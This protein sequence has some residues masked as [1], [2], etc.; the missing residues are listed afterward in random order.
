MGAMGFRPPVT[1]TGRWV[2]LVPLEPAHAPA[3]RAAGSSGEIWTTFRAGDLR[4]PGRM[5]EAILEL[6]ARQSA[7][8][9]LCFTQLAGPEFHP[10][11]M[12]RYLDIE[13]SEGGVEIGGTWLDRALW[14]TPVNTEA[15]YLLLRHAFDVEGCH[16]VQLKTDL[17]NLRSQAAIERIGA[18]REG[19]LREHMH[20]RDGWYRSSAYYSILAGE[21]PEVRARLE[22][23]LDRPWPS[24]ATGEGSRT[25][26][27]A[28]RGRP[29]SPP[30]ARVRAPPRRP[31][32][33][34][35]RAAPRSSRRTPRP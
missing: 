32:G 10:A 1:L 34:R 35:A 6:L 30:G 2:R 7:G 9:D 14:R 12:T 15:K 17:R 8:T 19:V 28:S 13:R 29:G 27:G 20:L 25:P 18:V 26:P 3:L 33:A 11:G 4:E 24:G 31:P 21:W 22:A 23:F 16:R 5:E